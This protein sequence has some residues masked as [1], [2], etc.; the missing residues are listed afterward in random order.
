MLDE[1]SLSVLPTSRH[2]SQFETVL[3]QGASVEI[4][5]TYTLTSSI[6]LRFCHMHYRAAC[7][8]YLLVDL[9]VISPSVRCSLCCS[10]YNWTLVDRCYLHMSKIHVKKWKDF[11]TDLGVLELLAVRQKTHTFTQSELVGHAVR[12]VYAAQL[13]Q[14][15][16]SS[17]TTRCLSAA[18]MLHSLYSLMP[19]LIR[20]AVCPQRVC[21]TACTV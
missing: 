7:Y 13:V 3:Y 1:L 15:N 2:S 9:Q 16:A 5:C 4:L 10:G 14:S 8:A 18:C 19:R 11:L 6:C 20:H 21:Y 12:S 17:N